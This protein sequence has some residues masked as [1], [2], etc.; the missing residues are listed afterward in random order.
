VWGTYLIGSR[1]ST[2]YLDIWLKNAESHARSFPFKFFF[3]LSD[4][5]KEKGSL[6]GS[7]PLKHLLMSLFDKEGT[8][9]ISKHF[10][11]NTEEVEF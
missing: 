10:I 5:V 4:Y 9:S 11:G 7:T 8:S 3:S 6:G 1:R 2:W